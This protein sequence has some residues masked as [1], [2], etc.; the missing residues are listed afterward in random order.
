MTRD[1]SDLY[2]RWAHAGEHAAAF[3]PDSPYGGD[4]DMVRSGRL[5]PGRLELHQA[6]ER[7]LAAT[8]GTNYGEALTVV[9]DQARTG[10]ICLSQ[11]ALE[12]TGIT[13][14]RPGRNGLRHHP[15]TGEVITL[16][17]PTAAP[18][19][20]PLPAPEDSALFRDAAGY[21][22]SRRPGATDQGRDIATQ[23]LVERCDP[24]TARR[25][26]DGWIAAGG[27]E[28]AGVRFG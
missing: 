17:A 19:G 9:L 13:G 7:Q 1:V 2:D 5:D 21:C 15:V 28:V 27:P 14:V 26:I 23:R 18:L 12:G 8:G 6:V 25:Q 24:A 20:E 11:Q 10:A 22:A 4:H 16:T 3:S